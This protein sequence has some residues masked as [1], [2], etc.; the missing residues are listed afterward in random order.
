M[1]QTVF[2]FVTAYLLTNLLEIV[3][4]SLLIKKPF[5]QKLLALLLINSITLPLLWITLPFFYQQYIVAF[6]IA[7]ALV[8]FGETVLIKLLLDQT[9]FTSF[10]VA[11]I[12][13][14]ISAAVGFI[15]F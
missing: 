5:D 2:S 6:I 8:V 3:P 1:I 9:T 10:K 14:V 15:F 7:E 12:I 4:F 13:N 11:V